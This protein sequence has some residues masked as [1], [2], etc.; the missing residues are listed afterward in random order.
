MKARSRHAYKS[1]MDFNKFR[2]FITGWKVKQQNDLAPTT[3]TQPLNDAKGVNSAPEKPKRSKHDNTS[4][5]FDPRLH[6][7]RIKWGVDKAREDH[8]PYRKDD[9]QEVGAS[10]QKPHDIPTKREVYGRLQD[11]EALHEVLSS[12]A[13]RFYHLALIR[14]SSDYWHH[15]WLT[16]H[17]AGATVEDVWEI[18]HN[19]WPVLLKK[20]KPFAPQ[21]VEKLVSFIERCSKV[22]IQC[23]SILGDFD[24][25]RERA[26]CWNLYKTLREFPI[27]PR[28]KRK[29]SWEMQDQAVLR[30]GIGVLSWVADRLQLE[31]I[32]D[33][34]DNFSRILAE[35]D[36]WLFFLASYFTK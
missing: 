12:S 28:W 29:V 8:K 33:L 17:L 22:V 32:M 1:V 6:R 25:G 23:D 5:L 2:Q 31:N 34:Y 14:R 11:L 10:L 3:G 7:H 36:Q 9:S 19:R 35:I 30:Q 27:A 16:F 18:A 4:P 21:E 24:F 26:C 15:I 20:K 13:E